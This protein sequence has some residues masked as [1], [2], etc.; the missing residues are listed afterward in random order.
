MQPSTQPAPIDQGATPE[1]RVVLDY[2]AH[3]EEGRL[4]EARSHLAPGA[5]HTFPGGRVFEDLG[6]WFDYFRSRMDVVRKQ[7][8]AIDVCPV[9]SGEG[10]VIVYVSGVLQGRSVRGVSF[11][12]VRFIDRFVVRDNAIVDQQV[13][14]DLASC[15]VEPTSQTSR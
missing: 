3:C 9:A 2:L 8:Q 11:D 1:V 12:Q 13:W 7:H 14:N 4:A 15:G 6:D 5:R 10:G